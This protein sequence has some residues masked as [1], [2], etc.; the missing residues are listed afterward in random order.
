MD[1]SEVLATVARVRR[2]MPRNTD[3]MVICDVLESSLTQRSLPLP[4]VIERELA[5][6]ADRAA[7]RAER[8]DKRASETVN[9]EKDDLYA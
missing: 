6:L 2:A 1:N 8:D 9:R 5:V 3:V 4:P 7:K